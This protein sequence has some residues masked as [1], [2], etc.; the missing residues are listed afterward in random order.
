MK[1]QTAIVLFS[2]DF[3]IKDN[4]ALHFACKNYGNIIPLYIH[5]ECYLG[6]TIGGASKVFLYGVLE[7]FNV[8][9]HKEYSINLVI[10]SGNV[11]D[12]LKIIISQADAIYFNSSYTQTQIQTEQ[13][14]KETF[15]YLDVQS[16]KAKVLFHPWEISPLSGGEFYRVFTP[17]SKE[18]LKNINLIGEPLPQPTEVK[19]VHSIASLQVEDLNLLPKNEG[20]WFEALLQYWEFSYE[21]IEENFGKFLDDKLNFYSAN[22]NTPS[23]QGTAGISPYLRFGMLSPRLCFHATTFATPIQDHQ[24]ILELLWREFAY[25]V[26]FYNQNIATQELKPAYKNFKWQHPSE[27]LTKWQEGE[28][29]YN[30]VDAGMKELYATG[31]MHNRVRMV[32]ASFLTKDLLINWK[33]GEQWFWNTLVDADPAINPFSWQWVFGSGFDAAPYFRIFNPESQQEKF[34]PENSYCKKWL[35]NTKRPSKIVDHSFQRKFTLEIYKNL[36]GNI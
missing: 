9:L 33:D 32:A 16:F 15:H 36:L 2:D 21:K 14:I 22:R 18:C 5:N 11:I 7:S 27:F 30:M 19:S 12:E 28:T 29:G 20:K 31:T 24:F 34:D 3:R 10:K 13:T 35:K 4:P 17:F 25:H 1:N 8:L 26:M 6:R 23:K